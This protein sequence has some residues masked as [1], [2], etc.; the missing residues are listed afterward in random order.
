M[1][2]YGDMPAHN[3]LWRE[4]E[5]T[6]DNV[7]AR[8]AAIPLV[9][10]ILL[11]FSCLVSLIFK[12]NEVLVQTNRS[13]K[14]MDLEFMIRIFSFSFSLFRL[15]EARGLDAGPRL[16]Q[17]MVGFGDNKTSK[18]VDRIADEEVA[19]VAVGVYWFVS[20][21]QKLGVLPCPTFKGSEAYHVC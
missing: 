19:H 12:S 6:S 11:K 7:A 10:V 17:K 9:Q 8:L 18:I 1:I 20:V 15:Q 2:R 21:C 3:L 4:C 16:V 13:V 14:P 5:K